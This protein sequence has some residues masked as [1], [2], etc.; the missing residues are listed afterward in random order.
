[1]FLE[2]KMKWQMLCLAFSSTGSKHWCWRCRNSWA[3]C[4]RTFGALAIW[5]KQAHLTFLVSIQLCGNLGQ[6]GWFQK[7]YS[8]KV[9]FYIFL[10]WL[11]VLLVAIWLLCHL[12]P[13]PQDTL[14]GV[15]ISESA[16]CW[17][18]CGCEQCQ[19]QDASVG[20]YC[21]SCCVSLCMHGLQC[22]VHLLKHAC[23]A[24]S[25]FILLAFF[26]LRG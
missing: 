2:Y 11:W 13:R 25:F 1:M 16:K 3:W 7:M 6:I 9:C 4:L 26:N 18:V 15:Q 24:L 22:T 8:S 23:L 21:P 5:S 12:K 19:C 17:N 20:L 10:V 14:A